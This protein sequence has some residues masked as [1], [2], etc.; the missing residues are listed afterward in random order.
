M[1]RAEDLLSTEWIFDTQT[2]LE[3]TIDPEIGSWDTVAEVEG[4]ACTDCWETTRSYFVRAQFEDEGT[5]YQSSPERAF[6]RIIVAPD[7][8]DGSKWALR[9]MFDLGI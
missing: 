9:A 2:M 1:T 5:I 7:E 6:V 8:S 4:E 3:L